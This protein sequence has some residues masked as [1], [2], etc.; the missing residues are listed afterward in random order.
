MTKRTAIRIGA[1]AVLALIAGC[2]RPLRPIFP[3]EKQSLVWPKPPDVPRIRYIGQ[4]TGEESL[5]ARPKGL[6]ALGAI[7]TGPKPK[8]GFS[9]PMAVAVH[10]DVVFVADAQNHAVYAL[11][12]AART[13]ATISQAAGRPLEWPIDLAMRGDSLLVVDSNRAA[14]FAYDSSGI[15]QQSMGQDVLKRPVAIAVDRASGELWVLDSGSHECKLFGADG[16]LK[17]AFGQRGSAPGQFNFPVGLS[18]HP[19]IGIAVADSMNFR[20]QLLGYDGSSKASFGQKGDAA[21]DFALPRDVA[22]DSQGHLYV[23]DNQFENVQIFDDAGR[24]L[25]AFGQEGL[26]P[27]EFYLPS[28]I[29]IDERDRIWVADT[30]NRRVQVFQYL[31]AGS[32]KE[33]GMSK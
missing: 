20:V 26:G 3:E 14:I 18:L 16:H 12:L 33:G 23:L 13:I 7:F 28:G 21:G 31:N 29:T 2:E 4:L 25:M 1:V 11:N 6:E 27:G 10:G 15:Y 32:E 19:A 9:T 30:Y 24:L 17:R 22:I 8:I 5:G